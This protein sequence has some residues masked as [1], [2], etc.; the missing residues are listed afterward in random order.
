MPQ[1]TH[2]RLGREQGEQWLTGKGAESRSAHRAGKGDWSGVGLRE[3]VGF[4]FVA[5]LPERSPLL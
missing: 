2:G 5:G 3:G 1:M 4:N